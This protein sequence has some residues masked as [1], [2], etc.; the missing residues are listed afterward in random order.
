MDATTWIVFFCACCVLANSQEE[1]RYEGR[2]MFIA[3]I[4]DDIPLNV[5]HIDLSSN[6]ISTLGPAD[7][8]DFSQL[9]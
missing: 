7:F 3:E 6:S 8:S 4:P 9:K 1:V 5:T 2:R